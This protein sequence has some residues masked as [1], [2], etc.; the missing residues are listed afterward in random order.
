M[1]QWRLVHLSRVR[2]AVVN[3]FSGFVVVFFIVIVFL[4]DSMCHGE[5]W[6]KAVVFS[7]MVVVR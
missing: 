6:G 7:G 2:S 4:G 3:S 5:N 1:M